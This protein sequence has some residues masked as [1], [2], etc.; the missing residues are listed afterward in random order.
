M[1]GGTQSDIYKSEEC[2]STMTSSTERM[3]SHHV[4]DDNCPKIC[5]FGQRVSEKSLGNLLPKTQKK[6]TGREHAREIPEN[7][8]YIP[9]R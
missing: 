6:K 9:S 2:T 8:A 4:V 3:L 1:T 5:E 7:K